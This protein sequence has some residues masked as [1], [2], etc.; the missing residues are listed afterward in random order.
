M[1][2]RALRGP[3]TGSRGP[4]PRWLRRPPPLRGPS[5]SIRLR[6]PIRAVETRNTIPLS[7]GAVVYVDSGSSD[8]SPEWAGKAGIEHR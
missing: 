7:V 1:Q 4:L 5:C 3:R 8:G 6:V 2:L